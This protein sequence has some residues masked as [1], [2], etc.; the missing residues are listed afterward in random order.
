MIQ[1]NKVLTVDPG[2]STG[3][4]YWLGDNKPF[5]D[6]IKLEHKEMEVIT[7]E[8][9][10]LEMWQKFELLYTTYEIKTTYIE[11]AAVWMGSNKSMAA[12]AT[13]S[14]TK[15]AYIIGGY[16]RICQQYGSEFKLIK[17]IHWKGTMHKSAVVKRIQRINGIKYKNHQA[18]AVGI[19]FGIMGIL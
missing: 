5:A 8:S 12:T 19:G 14:I 16:G 18:D 7:E 6:V 15:L 2:L 9:Q 3:W 13:G 17:P 4:A 11:S 1:L 10:V